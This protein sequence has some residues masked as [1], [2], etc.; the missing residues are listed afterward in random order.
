MLSQQLD[1]IGGHE[2]SPRLSAL[3]RL[4]FALHPGVSNPNLGG[5]HMLPAE[6]EEFASS[7]PGGQRGEEGWIQES[8]VLAGDLE[9]RVGLGARPGVDF[10]H[11]LVGVSTP[12]LRDELSAFAGGVRV[13]V[14][15]F[16]VEREDAA[17]CGERVLDRRLRFVVEVVLSA[18]GSWLARDVWAIDTVTAG[19]VEWLMGEASD[20]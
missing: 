18:D 12:D 9:Q 14:A 6:R 19:D 15:G 20:Y 3:R 2:D 13:Q 16:D 1:Q 11:P 4:D 5:A 17:Q 8:L 7:H 10:A